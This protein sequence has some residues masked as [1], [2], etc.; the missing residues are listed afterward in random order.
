MKKLLLFL[1]VVTSIT[2][3]SQVSFLRANQLNF[4]IKETPNS[5]VKWKESEVVDVLLKIGKETVTI[6]SKVT[7]VYHVISLKEKTTY[8]TEYTCTNSEGRVCNVMVFVLENSPYVFL[9]VEFSDV[10]WYYRCK[11][12]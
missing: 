7:Q 5:L 8:S 2:G 12:E 9:S 4:G 6:Y 11:P 1:F 10:V 3:Y